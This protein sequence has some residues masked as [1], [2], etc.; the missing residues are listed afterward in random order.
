MN[1]KQWNVNQNTNEMQIEGEREITIRIIMH[2]MNAR[3]LHERYPDSE[4]L[5]ESQNSV[6]RAFKLISN[7][8]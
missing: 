1:N 6:H 8:Q 7:C 4:W 5:A 2:I 3:G